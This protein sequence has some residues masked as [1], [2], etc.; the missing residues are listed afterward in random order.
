M[1][2]W[3]R[4]PIPGS[5]RDADLVDVACAAGEIE[6]HRRCRLPGSRECSR[7]KR[8]IGHLHDLDVLLRH[9]PRQYLAPWGRVGNGFARSR[10]PR[11]R[12]ARAP[13]K[14]RK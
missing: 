10:R 1:S 3:I 4:L 9:R 7:G 12:R 5:D 14:P 13:E 8:L 6:I 2:W 11:G